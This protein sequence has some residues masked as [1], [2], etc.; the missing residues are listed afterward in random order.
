MASKAGNEAD[1]E[2]EDEEEEAGASG[3]DNEYACNSFAV[4]IGSIPE[5]ILL[6]SKSTP[7]PKRVFKRNPLAT[8]IECTTA[9]ATVSDNGAG[10]DDDSE[11]GGFRAFIVHSGYGNEGLESVNRTELFIP[12]QFEDVMTLFLRLTSEAQTSNNIT[13][14]L[15]T[16]EIRHGIFSIEDFYRIYYNSDLHPTGVSAEISSEKCRTFLFGLV[17]SGILTL[18]QC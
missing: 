1:E 8:L 9:S 6:K 14:S 11:S 3:S 5:N 17:Q 13:I 7:M 10:N 2:E 4:T 18:A 16:L 12:D 15:Q